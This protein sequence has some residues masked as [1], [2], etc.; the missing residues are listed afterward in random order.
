M[1]IKII[2]IQNYAHLTKYDLPESP[3]PNLPNYLSVRLYPSLCFFEATSVSVGRGTDFPFQVL[4][5][6]DPDLGSFRFTPKSI[7]GV[8]V[9][10]PKKQELHIADTLYFP[11][12]NEYNPV[13]IPF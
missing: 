1:L 6:L 3:S 8:S 10:P 4:G 7:P 13:Q 12:N 11:I 2:P 9:N 5:G